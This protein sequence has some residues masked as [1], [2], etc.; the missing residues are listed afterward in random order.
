MKQKLFIKPQFLLLILVGIGLVVYVV[1]QLVEKNKKTPEKALQDADVPITTLS[2]NISTSTNT[3]V[4]SNTPTVVSL[5]A[6]SVANG[7]VQ[8]F[9]IPVSILLGEHYD[10]KIKTD[11]SSQTD[12]T[13]KVLGVEKAN[14]LTI[15]ITNNTGSNITSLPIQISILKLT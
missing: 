9:I 13:Y 7:N 10:Y 1:Y 6:Q 4:T 3:V 14:E 12:I 2:T 5:S 8:K 11:L 15:Q